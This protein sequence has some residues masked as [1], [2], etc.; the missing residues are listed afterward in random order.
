MLIGNGL[1]SYKYD[2]IPAFLDMAVYHNLLDDDL[3]AKLSESCTWEDFMVKAT[4]GDVICDRY[5]DQWMDKIDK[6][7]IYDIYGQCFQHSS[8]TPTLYNL[9]QGHQSRRRGYTEWLGGNY[10]KGLP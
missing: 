3:H 1:T 6:L 4:L 9:D 2:C 8:H 7:N 10:G 5:F